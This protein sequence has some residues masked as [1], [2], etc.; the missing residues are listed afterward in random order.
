VIDMLHVCILCLYISFLISE[1]I[2]FFTKFNI[3]TCLG[4]GDAD[5]VV[6]SFYLR[7]Q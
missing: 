1:S 4:T 7:L 6:N 5:W 3:V 2:D